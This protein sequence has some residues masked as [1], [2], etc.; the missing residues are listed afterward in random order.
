MRRP[1]FPEGGAFL[2]APFAAQRRKLENRLIEIIEEYGY[3][4]IATSV[5]LYADQ[6]E[7]VLPSSIFE[8]SY[9]L[10]DRFTGRTILI[11]PDITLQVAKL[12]ATL[13]DMKFPLKLSYSGKV[14]R[15]QTNHTGKSREQKQVGAEFFGSNDPSD[16][17]NFIKKIASMLSI[18]IKLIS[19]GN[20]AAI[21]RI[22]NDLHSGK[23][24]AVKAVASRDKPTLKKILTENDY[25]LISKSLDIYDRSTIKNIEN[26]PTLTK[27]EAKELRTVFDLLSGKFKNSD[28]IFDGA[29]IGRFFYYDG[30]TFS[31]YSKDGKEI[32][33]GGEYGTLMKMF[34][35]PMDAIGVAINLD[36]LF[37]TIKNLTISHDLEEI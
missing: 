5:F 3:H 11:R 8:Q 17:F 29:D 28:I 21:R 12:V 7:R 18:P 14:F 16:I 4:E 37:M 10:T 1:S 26:L 33:S 27:P 36:N 19:I 31:F 20:G 35:K 32:A 2:P 30:L 23:S 13:P 34:G 15:D 25:N 22:I 24:E 9:K 6:I